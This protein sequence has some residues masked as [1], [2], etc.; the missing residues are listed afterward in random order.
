[1]K[2]AVFLVMLV[3]L[4][5]GFCALGV[6]IAGKFSNFTCLKSSGRDLAIIRAYHSYGAIDTDAPANIRQSNLAGLLT[7]VY[8][9]PCRGKNATLQVNEM[10]DYLDATAANATSPYEYIYGTI[11]LDIET[12]PSTGCSWSVRS[13]AENC[14]FIQELITAI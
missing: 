12:N 1:M 9:F 8:L 7:D 11:W 10:I 3:L 6:D 13:S 2:I 14:D 5:F 4:Q